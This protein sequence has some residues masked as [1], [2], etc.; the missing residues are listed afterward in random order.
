MQVPK[1]RDYEL[2]NNDMM[3]TNSTHL[4]SQIIPKGMSKLQ[5]PNDLHKQKPQHARITYICYINYVCDQITNTC[6]NTS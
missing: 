1:T 6:S 4:R 3:C 2:I 5:N